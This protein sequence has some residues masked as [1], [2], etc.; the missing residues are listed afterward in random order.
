MTTESLSP[1]HDE[2]Q[3]YVDWVLSF[4]S[5]EPEYATVIVTGP[6]GKRN[7]LGHFKPAFDKVYETGEMKLGSAQAWSTREGELCHEILVCNE[8]L[9]G[10]PMEILTTVQHEI[11]HLLNW[12]DDIRDASKGGRHNAEFR[13]RATDMGLVVEKAQR[14]GYTTTGFTDEWAAKVREEFEP[15]EEAFYLFGVEPPEKEKGKSNTVPWHV[16]MYPEAPI[17]RV[18]KKKDL[19]GLVAYMGEEYVRKDDT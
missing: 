7:K 5:P 12:E 11:V 18:G 2:M 14:V 16:P 4:S 10:T 19:T 3:R 1:T 15:K 9:F 13:D 17:I 6:R 8:A